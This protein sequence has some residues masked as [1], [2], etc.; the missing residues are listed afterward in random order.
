MN[1]HS[2]LLL[3]LAF[4]LVLASGFLSVS[5][6]DTTDTIGG[7]EFTPPRVRPAPRPSVAPL[8]LEIIATGLSQ[9]VFVTA[10]PCDSRLFV[11]EKTGRI[12]IVAGGAVRP[13]PFL[14]VG[15]AIDALGERGLLGLAFDPDYARNGRFFICRSEAGT[16]DTLVTSLRVSADGD[17]ADPASERVL[18]RIPQNAACGDHK[19][20]WIGFRPGEPQN[21][22]IATGDGGGSNNPE[23]T[24]QDLGSLL[25]KI[26]RIDVS[27]SGPAYA[28]PADNPFVGSKTARPEIWA[29]GLR[30]PFRAS[31]DRL[32][33]DFYIG[34]VGQDTAEE[35]DFEPA[36]SRGGRN[37]GWRQREGRGDNPAVPEKAAPGSVPPLLDYLHADLMIQRGAVIGGYV[38]RGRT[39]PELNGRYFFADF[40]NGLVRSFRREGGAIADYEDHTA[41][42]NPDGQNYFYSSLTSFGE[43]SDG[44][45]YLT[46]FAGSLLKL[47]RAEANQADIP[48]LTSAAESPRDTQDP[49]SP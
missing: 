31:F 26:L 34:D 37:Y 39:L 43:G 46:C 20:G 15:E 22:Y 3:R 2:T 25:G 16:T 5:A 27:G 28:I 48:R 7:L 23:N 29:C 1:S 47:V 4:A 19:A 18:L 9:P 40:T 35:I 8:K 14:D 44:E 10:P 13:V 32:S 41:Q 49:E 42:L 6:V 17:A 36:T 33:G 21:L 45:L 24:A 30:N 38:Y 11:V 12:M